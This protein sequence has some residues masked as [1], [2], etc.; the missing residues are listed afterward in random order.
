M[1]DLNYTQTQFN[2]FIKK[3]EKLYEVQKYG[4]NYLNNI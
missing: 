4:N 3:L 2:E 1:I